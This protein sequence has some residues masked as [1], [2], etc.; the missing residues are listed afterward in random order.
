[1]M[2]HDLE[3]TDEEPEPVA[4]QPTK[5]VKTL[6]VKPDLGASEMLNKSGL[7]KTG[8]QPS[9]HRIEPVTP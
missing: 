8:V 1:M 3:C 9:S 2:Q 6:P 7:D 4:N 5:W